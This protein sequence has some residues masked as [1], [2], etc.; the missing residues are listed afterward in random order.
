MTSFSLKKL[1]CGAS[2]AV[3]VAG[4][5]FSA[6]ASG[7]VLFSENFDYAAGNLY[8]QGSWLQGAQQNSP[9]KVTDVKLTYAGFGSGKSV[10]LNPG[11]ELSAQDVYHACVPRDA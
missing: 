6:Q 9:I 8:P 2:A 5:L 1:R 7:E 10:E 11:E 4:M 3:L